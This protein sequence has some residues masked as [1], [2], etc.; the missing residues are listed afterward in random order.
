M[1][2]PIIMMLVIPMMCTVF[3]INNPDSLPA[4]IIS[5]IPVFTPMVMLM[6]ILVLTPPLWQILLSIALSAL[7]LWG[8]LWAVAKVFRIGVLMYGKR[9]TFKQVIQWF[10]AA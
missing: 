6:R 4:V 10:K 8:M 5:L 3:F 2:S 9:P 7:F 1:Q